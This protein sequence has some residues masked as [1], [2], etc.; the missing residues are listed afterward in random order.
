MSKPVV[1]MEEIIEAIKEGVRSANL[2][3]RGTDEEVPL[4]KQEKS[5]QSEKCHPVK[6]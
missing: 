2:P 1:S 6:E 4:L 5:S 3:I